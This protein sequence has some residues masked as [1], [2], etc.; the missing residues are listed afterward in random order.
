M[1]GPFAP[2][3][4]TTVEYAKSYR[5][6]Q[7]R[8]PAD[9]PRRQVQARAIQLRLPASMSC[10]PPR[11]PTS[12]TRRSRPLPSGPGSR[13]SP[14]HTPAR[15]RRGRHLDPGRLRRHHPRGHIRPPEDA[16]IP[17]RDCPRPVAGFA[18]A[19]LRVA[20]R[21][22]LSLVVSTLVVTSVVRTSHAQ[23]VI[24]EPRPAVSAALVEVC[25]S[26][27]GG[28]RIRGRTVE[29]GVHSDGAGVEGAAGA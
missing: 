14:P 5:A 18:P 19:D 8:R 10:G 27:E 12:G 3:S 16:P 13:T 2:M 1:C 7:A 9:P 4:T 17:A 21:V 22:A 6:E 29:R 26:A 28:S 15:P 20:L 25:T 11:S 24:T 23:A